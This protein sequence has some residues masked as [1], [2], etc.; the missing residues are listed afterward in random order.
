[1]NSSYCRLCG[2]PKA[3][4]EY[5]AHWCGVCENFGN[6]ARQ[7]CAEQHPEAT[8]D[9][10]SYVARMARQSRAHHAFSTLV[11]PRPERR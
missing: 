5:S 11:D 6:E 9:Q 2:G 8:E 3:V 1:M 4:N 7:A 10:L